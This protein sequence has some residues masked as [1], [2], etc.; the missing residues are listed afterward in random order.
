M[1]RER[2]TLRQQLFEHGQLEVPA[3]REHVGSPRRAHLILN[4]RTELV[5]LVV[6]DVKMV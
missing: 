4:Q 3:A 5:A 2:Q 1:P 6:V